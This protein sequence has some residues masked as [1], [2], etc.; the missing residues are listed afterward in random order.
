MKTSFLLLTALLLAVAGCQEPGPIGIVDDADDSALISVSY[1]GAESETAPFQSDVDTMGMPGGP[2]DRY[3]GRLLFSDVR[4]GL[5]VRAES[6]LCA[7]ALFMD[8]SRGIQDNGKVRAYGSIDAGT[9]D[10]SGDTLLRYQRRYR[11]SNSHA[12]TIIGPAYQ[13]RNRLENRLEANWTGSGSAEMARFT[14]RTQYA[15]GIWVHEASPPYLRPGEPLTLRWTCDNPT[16][17]ITISR[18]GDMLQKRWIPVLQL[19]VRNT[20]QGI[21]IPPK[22]LEILPLRRTERFMLT[23]SSE[24]RT[25]VRLHGYGDSVLVRSASLHNLFFDSIP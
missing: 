5:P 25:A 20:K 1:V 10:F 8:R 11:Y 2:S 21:T 16:V 23:I 12:D 9:I 19:Q 15:P 24:I 4:F 7:E 6:L 13:L 22:V 17:G 14:V 18:Q 3:F